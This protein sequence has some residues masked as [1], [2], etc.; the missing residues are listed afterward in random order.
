M[1]TSITLSRMRAVFDLF[2][3]ILNVFQI[4]EK[5]NNQHKG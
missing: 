5:S 3:C 1:H 4:I 2:K